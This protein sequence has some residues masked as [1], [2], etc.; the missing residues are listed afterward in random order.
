MSLDKAIKHKK[1][2]RKPYRGSKRFDPHCRNN[3]ACGWCR[4]NRTKFDRLERERAESKIK[5][6]YSGIWDI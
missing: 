1:E 3:N 4:K 6:F 5:E 2:F